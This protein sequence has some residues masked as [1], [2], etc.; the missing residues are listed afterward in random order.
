MK[1]L[2]LML[3][4]LGIA[5]AAVPASAIAAPAPRFASYQGGW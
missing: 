4:G 5:A 1:K 3:A 2:T